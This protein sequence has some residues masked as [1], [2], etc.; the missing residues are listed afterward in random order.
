MKN[1]LLSGIIFCAIATIYACAAN[2]TEVPQPI[3]CTGVN[4][5]SNT[6]TLAIKPILD[7][8][9]ATFACHSAAVMES[10]VNLSAYVPAVAAFQN[11]DALCTIK[12][13]GECL[14]MPDNQPKLADS[15]ITVIQCWAENGYKE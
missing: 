2:K 6:Y 4:V 3:V 12:Q 11:K 13:E 5:D 9:C 1:L 10:N 15:L 8:N 7:A 14:P